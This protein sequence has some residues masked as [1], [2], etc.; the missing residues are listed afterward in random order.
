M[1]A[2]A[3]LTALPTVLTELLNSE[4]ANPEH[5]WWAL[6]L[7]CKNPIGFRHNGLLP[8]S[9]ICYHTRRTSG[10]GSAKTRTPSTSVPLSPRPHLL[11]DAGPIER[12]SI[13]Q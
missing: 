6:G 9:F 4:R 11:R 12:V 3:S 7:R 10:M 8:A 1:A 5:Q 13:R 2:Q